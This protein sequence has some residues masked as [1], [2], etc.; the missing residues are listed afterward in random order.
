VWGAAIRFEHEESLGS[1][2]R[3]SNMETSLHDKRKNWFG[4]AGNSVGM[5]SCTAGM[6]EDS[7][8]G[9]SIP[10]AEAGSD[11]SEELVGTRGGW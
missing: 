6:V 10:M 5:E 7:S 4:T 1:K 8:E 3:E 9:N 11:M 2:S